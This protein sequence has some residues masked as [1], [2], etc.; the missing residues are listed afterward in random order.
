MK[1]LNVVA[2]EGSLEGKAKVNKQTGWFP[3]AH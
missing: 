3:S 1:K 2:K